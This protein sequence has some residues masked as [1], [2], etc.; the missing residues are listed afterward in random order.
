MAAEQLTVGFMKEDEDTQREAVNV[1]VQRMETPEARVV[2][3]APPS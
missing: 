3:P 1:L 2:L